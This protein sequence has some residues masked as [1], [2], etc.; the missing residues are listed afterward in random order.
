MR[1]Q[2]A[3]HFT[4]GMPSCGSTIALFARVTSS[5]DDVTVQSLGIRD[6]LFPKIRIQNISWVILQKV[7]QREI[8]NG[9]E[10]FYQVFV[11][12]VEQI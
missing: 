3:L 6:C 1:P 9:E 12:K 4:S 10:N 5:A 11:R 8:Q 2:S 7:V